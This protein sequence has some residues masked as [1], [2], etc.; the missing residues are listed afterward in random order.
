M[1]VSFIKILLS[2]RHEGGS[3]SDGFWPHHVNMQFAAEEINEEEININERILQSVFAVAGG[4]AHYPT[5]VLANE[6]HSIC[7]PYT[8]GARNIRL[9]S[10]TLAVV[11]LSVLMLM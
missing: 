7:T 10:V 3:D 6:T 5:G 8:A 1:C 9:T 2:C 4:H 11:V